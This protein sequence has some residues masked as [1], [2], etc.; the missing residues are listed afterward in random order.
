MLID[1]K[2]TLPVNER[3]KIKGKRYE[4]SLC[5]MDNVLVDFPFGIEC[6]NDDDKIKYEGNYDECPGIFS[7]M[8]PI[9]GA[10]DSYRRLSKVFDTYILSTSPWKNPSAWIHKLEW[11]QKHLGAERQSRL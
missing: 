9:P 1:L 10:I 6:L 5:S 11:V 3:Y 2:Q 8:R 7:L 4:N